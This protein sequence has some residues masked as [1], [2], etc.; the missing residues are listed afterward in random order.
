MSLIMPV[1]AFVG[2]GILAWWIFRVVA[3]D[4]RSKGSLTSRSSFLETAIFFVH[5]CASYLYLGSE[6]SAIRLSSLSFALAVILLAVGLVALYFSMSRL[7]WA[8]SLGQEA[9]GLQKAGLYRVSRNPQI[10]AYSLVV[11][12]YSLLWPSLLGAIW[13]CLYLVIAHMMVSAEEQHLAHKFGD[14][15]REYCA[16]TP[17]YVGLAKRS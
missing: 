12:G 4:Y 13:V 2:I 6:L 1:A 16:T 17:R 7:R 15:Y 14:E 8:V 5:G 10:V 3:Q 9:R 11:V